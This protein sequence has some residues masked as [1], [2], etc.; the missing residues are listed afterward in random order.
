[1]VQLLPWI[2][3]LYIDNMDKMKSGDFVVISDTLPH[4][5]L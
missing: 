4:T 3:N 5:F 2:V 1:M